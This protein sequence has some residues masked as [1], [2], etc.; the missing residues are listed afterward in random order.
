MSDTISNDPIPALSTLTEDEEMF[1]EAVRD[2]AVSEIMPR[3]TEMD[4]NQA[5]DADLLSVEP[6]S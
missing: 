1:K 2:F 5:L 4:E 6:W 3:A